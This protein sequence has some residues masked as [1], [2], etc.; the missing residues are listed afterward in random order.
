MSVEMNVKTESSDGPI[1]VVKSSETVSFNVYGYTC[2]GDK[3]NF[4]VSL[5]WRA[6]LKGTDF[7]PK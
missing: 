2:M 7:L 1:A 3:S 5:C 4:E 6:S